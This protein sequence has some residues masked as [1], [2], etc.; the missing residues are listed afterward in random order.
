VI[1]AVTVAD[2]RLLVGLLSKWSAAAA[3]VARRAT[4]RSK[5]E[6]PEVLD[7]MALARGSRE[8]DPR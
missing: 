2:V 1:V 3:V 4:T 5:R 7:A 8:A 6:C